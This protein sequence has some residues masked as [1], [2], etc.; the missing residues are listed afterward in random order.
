MGVVL[1]VVCVV[2]VVGVVVLTVAL[3]V[4]LVVAGVVGGVGPFVGGEVS[5]GLVV[6]ARVFAGFA[7][8]VGRAVVVLG[9]CFKLEVSS[10]KRPS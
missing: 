4:R 3:V 9:G 10:G 5:G 1:V 8:V 2:G 7:R 6:V